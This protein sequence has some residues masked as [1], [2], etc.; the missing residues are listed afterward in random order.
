MGRN[1]SIP[2]GHFDQTVYDG[3]RMNFCEAWR[4]SG[5]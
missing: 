2:F 4:R 5:V 3:L 1:E